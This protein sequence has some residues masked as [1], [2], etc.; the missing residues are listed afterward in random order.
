MLKQV[1]VGALGVG[2]SACLSDRPEFATLP[3]ASSD[4]GVVDS[5]SNTPTREEADAEAG[6]NDSAAS[7]TEQQPDSGGNTTTA[8]PGSTDAP[9]S[10]AESSSSADQ[11]SRSST[12]SSR[13]DSDAGTS[14]STTT[15]GTPVCEEGQTWCD[16]CVDLNT[17]ERY[18]GDCDTACGSG[19][20]CV[21]GDCKSWGPVSKVAD[22]EPPHDVAMDRSGNVTVAYVSELSDDVFTV[23]RKQ[24][25]RTSAD[26]QEL[27]STNNRGSFYTKGRLGTDQAGNVFALWGSD[28]GFGFAQ[29]RVGLGTWSTP[30]YV[31]TPS[32]MGVQSM[33][34]P[35]LAVAPLGDAFIAWDNQVASAGTEAWFRSYS[36]SSN[37]WSAP[38]Q[39]HANG[40]SD[41]C[42]GAVG[43]DPGGD[44]LVVY[45]NEGEG[46]A[47]WWDAASQAWRG[48]ARP[49][50]PS[51]CYVSLAFDG[52][53]RA[54]IASYGLGGLYG[55]ISDGS[56][57]WATELLASGS[58]SYHFQSAAFTGRGGDALVAFE[59]KH[60][61]VDVKLAVW[62]AATEAW[63][64]TVTLFEGSDQQEYDGV[65]FA[66]DDLG[67]GFVMTVDVTNGRLV[68]R[69]R[70]GASGDWGQEFTVGSPQN[71]G[72]INPR[73]TYL[74][75]TPN[76]N[77]A[78]V[79]SEGTDTGTSIWARVYE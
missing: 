72:E 59:H 64:G 49:L 71:S 6:S 48:A 57:S 36:A 54:V 62:S 53:G 26:A 7:P 33:D 24:A 44:G 56:N 52:A 12:N 5:S 27:L 61:I 9:D 10:S 74:V 42:V 55:S 39:L 69:R 45:S 22:W 38:Q 40:T 34:V 23:R 37:S 68:A 21:N 17:D 8:Q 32:R 66:L 78:A 70:D 28:G 50:N 19:A 58:G 18:C 11:N 1:L 35:R 76:G 51:Y 25:S 75:V 41:A 65:N 16:E 31:T 79:W 30:S 67:N 3:T 63:Q 77:A 46:Y 2:V 4:A 13:G 60:T 15:S 47:R 29:Y 73:T 14:T 20:Q 43:A